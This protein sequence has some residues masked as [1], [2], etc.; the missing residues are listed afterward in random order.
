MTTQL[1]SVLVNPLANPLAIPLDARITKAPVLSRPGQ[2]QTMLA[3]LPGQ[4]A[5]PA[6]VRDLVAGL[7]DHSPFLWRLAMTRPEV[8][9]RLLTTSPEE[10][11]TRILAETA[12]AG[13]ETTDAATLM[14]SLR[15][16]RGEHALLVALADLGGVWDLQQVIGSLSAFADA[17]VETTVHFLLRQAVVAG[18]FAPPDPENPGKD[19]GLVVLALGK[20]GA[21][22]LNYSS[23]IDLVLF[24]DPAAPVAGKAEASTFFVKL[25]RDLVKLLQE[26]TGDGYV[27]RVDLRLRPDPGSTAPAVSLPAAFSYYE[28][29]GQ[30][31]ERAAYIKARPVAGDIAAGEQFI[32]ELK[33]FIW[34]KYFDFAAIADIHAMKRQIH[35]V[36]GHGVIAV[37]GHDIKLG[38]GGI[39]EIEFFV[40]TQ[41]LVFGGR[42]P[43]LRGRRTLDMLSALVEDGWITAQARD[44]LTTAYTFL[45]TTEHRL[46]MVADEQTQRLPNDDETLE[47]FARFCGFENT[48]AFA[49]ELTRHAGIV[50]EHYALLFEDGPDLAA[51]AGSLVF[52]GSENDPET[53]ETLRR[54]GF[55]DPEQVAETVRGWHFGRRKAVTSARAREVLTELTPALLTALGRTAAPDA[56]LAA[57]D[58]AFGR[59][60]AGVELL[61]ILRSNE[62]LLALFADLLGIA[63]R[64]TEIVA[65][66]P[67]V[68]DA[69]IDPT[70]FNSAGGVDII[71]TRVR[72]LLGQGG[73]AVSFEEFLDRARD[74]ARQEGFFN[75]ARLISGVITPAQAAE[76]YAVIAET[77]VQASLDAAK[78]M[79]AT[80]HGTVEGARLVVLGFGRLGSR[81]MTAGSDLDLVTLYDFDSENTRSSGTRPLDVVVYY[82]RLTQR[83]ISALT[84]P[85]RRGGL[86]EV[87]MRLRPSGGQGPVA[88]QFRGFPDYYATQA[89]L[90]E[91]MALT[92]ARFV[93]GDEELGAEVGSAIRDI[94]CQQRDLAVLA[95]AVR[96]MRELIASE[97]G[98]SD[99]WD[100]KLAAGGLIDLEF[101]AQYLILAHAHRFPMLAECNNTGVALAAAGQCGVIA[102]DD[103]A[104]LTES[105]RLLS[106]VFQ[107][108]RLTV[109]GAFA[110]AAVPP[111]VV[112][113][114]ASAVGLPDARVL[115]L[116]LDETRTKV[117]ALFNKLL[118]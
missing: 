107:W 18:R 28:T 34:R 22:E 61:S 72:T 75:G 102:A 85:T 20:H 81:E 62:R 45:R 104:T 52:T 26:R 113:R 90:W 93:A 25:A 3:D 111:S 7:A 39:R 112:T 91:H 74:V 87:D 37:S 76:G 109:K 13:R 49:R 67:H 23:D 78:T 38:R 27:F 70:F 2:A 105:Y 108:Q 32:S 36:K 92:R 118:A 44:D 82:A 89:D 117:R 15:L 16:L 86:Y 77:L 4:D 58:T 60:S 106:D 50:Q 65:M 94:L 84:A 11:R 43:S 17:A 41:Q 35:A 40:Q 99:P 68:L 95:S 64:L 88:S 69:V 79:F 30:N 96:E 97:K 103:C 66:S 48:E 1:S 100:L 54:L 101:I 57:L 24:Y 73:G 21:G 6:L 12:A 116:H 98:D 115:L 31:W 47:N 10:S 55:H 42:R 14:R 29:V 110:P 9:E 5:W 114:I 56:A 51:E 80:D 53:M 63:P 8:L 46:Q 33:P 59:I 19:S 71:A 83:L